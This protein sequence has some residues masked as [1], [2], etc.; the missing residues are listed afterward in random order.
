MISYKYIIR[1]GSLSGKVF[2]AEDRWCNLSRDK[3]NGLYATYVIRSMAD[4]L[5][6]DENI[7]YGRISGLEYLVHISELGECLANNKN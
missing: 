1:R 4:N 3:E 5:T 7:L 6:S 2:E